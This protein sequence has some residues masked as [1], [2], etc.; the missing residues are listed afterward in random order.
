MPS[1]TN[2]KPASGGAKGTQSAQS[3]SREQRP[4]QRMK[5]V[6]DKLTPA[7]VATAAGVTAAAAVAGVVAK[8]KMSARAGTTIDVAPNANGWQVKVSG[9]QRPSGT[10][11]LKKEAIEAGRE[12]ARERAPSELVIHKADG[13]E[14]R[15]HEYSASA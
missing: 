7:R 8:K 9:N 15:R 10:F 2:R 12:L 6:L 14:Q 3:K 13:S 11:E 1:T 5:G 4:K